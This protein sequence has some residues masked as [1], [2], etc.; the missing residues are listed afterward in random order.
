MRPPTKT[1]DQ[2]TSRA[3]AGAK[4]GDEERMR[5]QR[6]VGPRVRK[7]P[8]L[9][10]CGMQRGRL[11]AL[12][13]DMLFFFG[14]DWKQTVKPSPE[15]AAYVAQISKIAKTQPLLLI[16]HQYTRYL[17]NTTLSIITLKGS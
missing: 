6:S 4:W 5:R 3:C 10:V 2:W 11:P 17:G 8:L 7:Q 9:M 16:S 15:T 1:F 12:E 13:Q 14:E